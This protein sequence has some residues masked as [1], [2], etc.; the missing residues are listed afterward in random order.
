M[1][2]SLNF[3]KIFLLL[4]FVSLQ[5]CG[6]KE[7]Q[8]SKIN[9]YA[10]YKG[11]HIETRD[12]LLI[13]HTIKEW[14]KKMWWTWAVRSDMYKITPDDVTYFIA[15]TF[16]SPD[17]LKILVW[18]GEKMPNAESIEKTRDESESNKI[19][20]TSGDTVYT[21]SS[22][23]GMRDNMNQIWRLY[24]FDQK[25]AVCCKNKESAIVILAQ[26]YFEQ[27]KTDQM[28]RMI[29]SGKNKGHKE[30]QA[31]GYNLQDKDFWQKCW[32]FE[33]DTVGSYGLYPFQIK[34]YN[35]IG[36]KC[37]QKCAEPYN[38]PVIDYP[39]EILKLYK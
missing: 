10:K 31:Y 22:V 1:R 23:I 9:R 5:S 17:K 33:K 12:S 30:S 37:S 38:P 34:G 7:S 16:Y 36:D 19:C 24:P 35:Y 2:K 14:G 39:E 4:F 27:M 29:Q 6:Q 26:Y 8:V 3:I 13:I 18:I 32:L 11:Q 15:G 28:Y 21:L 25:Q 20:P